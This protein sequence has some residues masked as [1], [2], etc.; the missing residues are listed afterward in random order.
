MV[1]RLIGSRQSPTVSQVEKGNA[2]SLETVRCYLCSLIL[3]GAIS[4]NS[5]WLEIGKGGQNSACSRNLSN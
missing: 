4:S 3:R 1:C 5:E 2:G